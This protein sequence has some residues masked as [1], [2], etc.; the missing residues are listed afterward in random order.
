MTDH[1][2]ASIEPN[3]A[4][5]AV[6][7]RRL[8]DL[9]SDGF[10]MLLLVK[11]GQTPLTQAPFADATRQ[12]LANMERTATRQ[13][14]SAEDIHSAKYAYCAAVDESIL[15]SDC[16]FRE[17]WARNPL[18]LSLFGD[19]LAGENFFTRLEELRAQGAARLQSLEVFYFCLLLGFEG[20]YRLEGPEK[21]GYLT[22]RLGDEIVYLKGHRAG[23]APHWARPD[24][25]S[26][27]LRRTVPLWTTAAILAVVG[28]VGYFSLRVTLQH[29]TQQRLAAYHNLVELPAR[30]ANLTITL[31]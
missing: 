27:V 25:V 13:G 28:L 24:K 29:D 21:L 12:F 1:R 19:H 6:E 7:P 15:S 3:T 23:F 10:Y 4:A 11:R 17:D 18:Q 8:L 30:T 20:K 16:A 2:A 31:P 9:M 5:A 26:H 14:V 22:A